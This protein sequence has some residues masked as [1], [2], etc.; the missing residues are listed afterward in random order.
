MKENTIERIY[1]SVRRINH[2]YE[3]WAGRCGLT[4]YEMQ[5]YY[6]ILRR[7]PETVTQR[8]LCLELEAPKTSVNGIIRRQVC[9]GRIKMRVNPGN[10]REKIIE[11]TE[12]GRRFA[13][14]IILPLF[15]FEQ[16]TAD[17]LDGSAVEEMFGMQDEIAETLLRK[18]EEY[19]E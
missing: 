14:K 10:R 2:A 19:H 16:E 4:L 12:S 15:L 18:V 1:E 5:I 17:M 7:E 6:V 8:E 13:E 3:V 9:A 11:L